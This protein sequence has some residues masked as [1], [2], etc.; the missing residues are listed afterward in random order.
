MV[1]D[2]LN[3]Y[4]ARMTDIII[5]HGGTINEFIG[6]AIFAVFG[7]PLP[8]A[9]HT[10]RAAGAALAMQRAMAE[11]NREH[12]A[13]GLPPFAMGIGI[14]TGEAVVGN[15]GS[16]QRAKYAVVGSAVNV[17]ARVES[18]TVGGQVF[19]TA[20]THERIRDIAEVA[21]PVTVAVKGLTEPLRLYELRG[22]A[23]RFAQARDPRPVEPDPSVD[24][25]WPV[26]CWVIEEKIVRG[27]TLPGTVRR[28]GRHHLAVRLDATLPP[29]T[30][31]RLR[32]HYPGLGRSSDDVYGKVLGDEPGD[33][34]RL[35]RI[36]L[37]S[38]TDADRKV[39]DDVLDTAGRPA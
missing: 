2:V 4:L 15:I 16:E 36:H 34:H 6:D 11:I 39:L 3:G 38:V 12:E 35:T 37:T 31:V 28:L 30:N 19:L 20:S 13:R 33:G 25:T 9:D 24:V 17:A 7:A 32:V 8:H 14:N 29:L 22:L 27:E 5:E 1:M 26:T 10:E 18:A 21:P 23:G